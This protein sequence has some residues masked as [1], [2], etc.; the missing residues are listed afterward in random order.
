MMYGLGT[1][2]TL[3]R[4]SSL[5]VG[6]C[7]R[8]L[9]TDLY[10]LFP[11]ECHEHCRNSLAAILLNPATCPLDLQLQNC[12]QDLVRNI[13]QFKYRPNAMTAEPE[14]EEGLL[15]NT[16]GVGGS[17]DVESM[18][19]TVRTYTNDDISITTSTARQMPVQSQ[20]NCR[21]TVKWEC[22]CS[23]KLGRMPVSLPS[24]WFVVWKDIWLPVP[25][26]LDF[27]GRWSKVCQG[28]RHQAQLSIPWESSQAQAGWS[29]WSD[30]SRLTLR[31]MADWQIAAK[32]FLWVTICRCHHI[33][34]YLIF[35]HALYT[36]ATF[37][38]A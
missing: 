24:A 37:M 26:S 27:G 15:E 20:E 1:A 36:E 10:T 33:A 16:R 8:E 3:A 12:K 4:P 29:C 30:L 19:H 18:N 23:T 13:L 28:W 17:L 7:Q 11:D 5:K 14:E 25:P 21:R 31:Q 22:A 38:W 2:F 34:N 9:P 32:A 6:I 35:L